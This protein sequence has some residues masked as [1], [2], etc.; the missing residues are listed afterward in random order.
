MFAVEKRLGL[1]GLE[2]LGKYF[3]DNMPLMVSLIA[4]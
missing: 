4:R 1:R 2:G 3:F